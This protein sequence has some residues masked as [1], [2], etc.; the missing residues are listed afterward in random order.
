MFLLLAW[1]LILSLPVI[2]WGTVAAKS[3][4]SLKSMFVLVGVECVLLAV[5]AAVWPR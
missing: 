1:T 5:L 2:A 3:R 4:V